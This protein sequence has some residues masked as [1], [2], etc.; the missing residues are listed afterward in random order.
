MK[1]VSKYF[2][3]TLAVLMLLVWSPAWAANEGAAE[4][5]SPSAAP[6]GMAASVGGLPIVYSFSATSAAS[7]A[8]VTITTPAGFFPDYVRVIDDFDAATSLFC[9][10]QVGMPAASAIV[11]AGATTAP[12]G[13]YITSNGITVAAGSIVIGTG[14]QVNSGNVLGLAIR[15][16]K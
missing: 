5:K 9:E 16:S 13:A 11:T 1:N 15:Y 10:W 14:C 8:A 3:A 2:A 7:E 12:S 4:T 6:S